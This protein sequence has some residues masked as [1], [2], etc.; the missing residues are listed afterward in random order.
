MA[1]SE[2]GDGMDDGGDTNSD[3]GDNDGVEVQGGAARSRRE[4][5]CGDSRRDRR[6]S[7]DDDGVVFA[8]LPL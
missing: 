1:L 7:I 4:G 3:R 5:G 6:W 8:P 2:G